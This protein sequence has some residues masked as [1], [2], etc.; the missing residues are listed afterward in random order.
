MIYKVTFKWHNP[1]KSNFK[2]NKDF[3]IRLFFDNWSK[4]EEMAVFTSKM[5]LRL[6][7]K[8]LDKRVDSLR[9]SQRIYNA[10]GVTMFMSGG[11]H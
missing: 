2:R 3:D 7:H 11:D 8:R 9:M 4:K 6:F 10:L 5:F 1:E